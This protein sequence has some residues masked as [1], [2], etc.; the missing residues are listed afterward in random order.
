MGCFLGPTLAGLDSPAVPALFPIALD[1][2]AGHSEIL[3]GADGE[4]DAQETLPVLAG[5]V[6]RRR[7]PARLRQLPFEQRKPEDD[8]EIGDCHG[9]RQQR[10]T[11]AAS[12]ADRRGDP[13]RGRGG[14]AAH[15]VL[16]NEITPPPM[17]PMPET[18]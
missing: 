2:Q 11:G 8:D 13:Y 7:R 9:D 4:N 3:L 14:E 17:K 18:I 10:Q 5:H 1:L 6:K 16:A 15:Q 12:H